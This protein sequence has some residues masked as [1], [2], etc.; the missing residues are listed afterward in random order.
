[1]MAKLWADRIRR[2]K[3]NIDDVPAKLKAEVQNILGVTEND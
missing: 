3:N 1:M 2:G